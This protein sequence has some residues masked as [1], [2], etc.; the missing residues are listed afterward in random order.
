MNIVFGGLDNMLADEILYVFFTTN[1]RYSLPVLYYE[2]ESLRM[3]G[4]PKQVP[5][6]SDS[7]LPQAIDAGRNSDVTSRPP[8]IY[9]VDTVTGNGF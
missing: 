3:S 2:I 7:T 8:R 9:G 6:A 4:I 5:P 1:I